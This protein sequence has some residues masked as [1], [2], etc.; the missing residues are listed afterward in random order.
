MAYVMTYNT[1]IDSVQRWTVRQTDADYTAELPRLI[2]S[3]ERK[4]SRALKTLMSDRYVDNNFVVGQAIYPKPLRW[5]ESMSMQFAPTAT[6][7]ASSGSGSGSGS[8]SSTVFS[9]N[10]NIY[11]RSY[12]YLTTAY[13]NITSADP[14]EWGPP[15][16]YSD[17]QIDNFIFGPAPDQAYPFRLRYYERPQPL[18]TTNSTN[19]LTEYA[20]DMMLYGLLLESIPF[21]ENP[22][23]ATWQKFYDDKKMQLLGEDVDRENPRSQ[24]AR[25]NTQTQQA[26][27][28]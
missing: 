18:D 8:G 13:P 10:G 2:D 22:D 5:L 20:P 27:V 26:G 17:F 28:Q 6:I 21:L 1:L 9:G 24:R 11:Y 25:P 14:T 15:A 3:T 19:W 4:V 7:S 12:E 16:V 23:V